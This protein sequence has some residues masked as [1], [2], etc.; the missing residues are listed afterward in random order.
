MIRDPVI[1][2]TKAIL[3]DTHVFKGT[4]VP[5]MNLIDYLEAG[6]SLDDFL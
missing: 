4:R 5:V 6:D 2:S 1:Q 3:G